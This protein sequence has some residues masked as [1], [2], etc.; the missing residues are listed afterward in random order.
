[1]S[2][3]EKVHKNIWVKN[4]KEDIILY[5]LS[6]HGPLNPSDFI[7]DYN[8][9]DNIQKTTFY[10]YFKNLLAKNYVYSEV[11]EK[12]RKRVKYFITSA[13]EIHLSKRLILYGLD[14]KTRLKMETRRSKNLI[15]RLQVFFQENKIND[16]L[17]KIEFINLASTLTFEKSSKLFIKENQFNK[18]LLFLTLNH[19][20]FYPRLTISIKSF[21]EKYNNISEGLLTVHEI[22]LFLERLLEKKEDDV[23]FHKITVPTKDGELYFSEDSEYGKLFE[24]VIDNKLKN[25]IHKTNLGIID[26]N[27]EELANIYNEIIFTLVDKYKLFHPDF[28]K[29]L[30]NLIDNF[31]KK[32]REDVVKSR[33]KLIEY[34]RVAELPDMSN[35][36]L[37]IYI[38]SDV[39]SKF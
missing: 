21:I 5:A 23:N 31:R 28:K 22:S 6:A 24:F 33:S 18:L 15:N 27:Q 26:F 13:G 25:F 8:H 9:P 12:D 1:M 11:D 36:M 29:D 16:E 2:L 17:V 37:N 35:E 10:K 19:P 39:F 38:F 34:A 32:I 7:R 4:D 3:K 20:L 14:Y 30:Y